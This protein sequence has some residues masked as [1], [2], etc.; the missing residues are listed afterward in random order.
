MRDLTHS[1]LEGTSSSPENDCD[2]VRAAVYA[3]TSSR[4]QQFGYSLEEQIQQCVD[5]CQSMN[6]TVAFIFKD[7]AESGK[8]TERPMFQK[9]MRRAEQRLFDVIVFWK[10]DRFSRTLMHAVKLESD[11]RT[12]E[13][14]LY[15]ATEQIDT[16]SAAGRFNFR[17]IASAAEF[18]RD[19]IQQRSQMGLHALARDH[20]WPNASP[21]L[22]YE[23]D[24]DDSLVIVPPEA[25]FV[26]EIFQRYIE[27]K[28]MPEVAER[29]NECGQTTKAGN[30]WTPRSVRDIL[31]NSLYVGQYSVA[32][33]DDYV[34]A[35]RIIDD[36][37]FE[38]AQKV[39]RRF[40]S[41]G[42][43]KR[44]SMSADRKAA[45]VGKIYDDYVTFL[46]DA[47]QG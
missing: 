34:E 8:D 5:R 21:P 26:E 17:N 43:E 2:D 7:E 4:N 28:S 45:A 19:M 41:N 12:H 31:T 33:V 25:Q 3:R 47:K 14:G 44:Q 24:D 32:D 16:T 27:T 18:E 37:L 6:W 35:Y 9:M 30:S 29:L 46:E 11:L 36:S 40:Q 10:L 15:S 23:K 20:R 1:L 39:R 13:V 38:E 22:G 42:N